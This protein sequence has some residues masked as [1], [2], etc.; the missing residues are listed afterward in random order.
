MG[1]FLGCFGFTTK[2]QKR[3]KPCNKFQV[4][5]KYV[6]LNSDK[7]NA[8]DSVNSELRD[9]PKESSKP[10]VKKKVSFNLNVKAYERIQDDDNNTTYFSDEEEKTQCEYNEQETAKSSMSMYPSSY[11]Y[12]NCN[13]EEEDEITLE[14]SDIDDLDEEDYGISDDD[15]DDNEDGDDET[16]DKFENDKRLNKDET[17]EVGKDHRNLY[18][19]SVLLPVENLTQWKA[20]KAKGAQQ[21]KHQ[22][23]NINK[24]DGKQEIPLLKKPIINCADLNPKENSKP[25]TRGHEIP[26]DA[27]LSNW[28]VS[29]GAASVNRSAVY[30]IEDR[31]KDHQVVIDE[32]NTI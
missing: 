21:V 11:R 30:Y 7:A 10:K 8:A 16:E 28:L 26:V 2:K 25:K 19:N 29:Q 31:A 23:E 5:Q 15:D 3:I 12:Y 22:K 24:S 20:V 27:S 14:E 18:A 32:F 13:D 4:H 9:K 17:N 6:Q 1:C